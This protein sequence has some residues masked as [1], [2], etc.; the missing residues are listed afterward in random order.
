MVQFAVIGLGRFG[1]AASLELMRLGHQ[2][3]GIDS[4]TKFINRLADQ[5]SHAVIADATDEQALQEL[6]ITGCDAALVAIGE[7]QRWKMLPL[8]I[9]PSRLYLPLAR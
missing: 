4:N 1:S 8:W 7:K 6:D 9:L 2:V 5:L 3:I